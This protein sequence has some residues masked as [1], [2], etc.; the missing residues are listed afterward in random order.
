MGAKSAE[1]VFDYMQQEENRE[2]LRQLE[3]VGFSFMKKMDVSRNQIGALSG[4]TILFTGTLTTMTRPEA[5]KSS[6]SRCIHRRYAHQAG[7]SSCGGRKSWIKI[8][9][10][11]KDADCY[12]WRRSF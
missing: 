10:S 11:E 7:H 4:M 5:S 1:S 2:L 6:S 3:T 8:G 9:K 12:V